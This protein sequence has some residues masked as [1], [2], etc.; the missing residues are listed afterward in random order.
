MRTNQG[1]RGIDQL[2]KKSVKRCLSGINSFHGL[3]S[4]ESRE[5]IRY[6]YV[7]GKTMAGLRMCFTCVISH[8]CPAI[9]GRGRIKWRIK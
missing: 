8:A 5:R 1:W 2:D 4:S 9:D 7:F 3:L 6:V